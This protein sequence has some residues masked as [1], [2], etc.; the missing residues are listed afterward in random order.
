MRILPTS[1]AA[2]ALWVVLAISSPASSNA[3][4]DPHKVAAELYGDQPHVANADAAEH[5]IRRRAFEGINTL[6]P[7]ANSSDYYSELSRPGYGLFI[8]TNLARLTRI[9]LRNGKKLPLPNITLEDSTDPYAPAGGQA[10][11]MHWD[12][13]ATKSYFIPLAIFLAA[14][15]ITFLSTCCSCCCICCCR[16]KRLGRS[17]KDPY[18][19][20][21]KFIAAF[22]LAL[23]TLAWMAAIAGGISGAHFFG[24]SV[25]ILSET[26]DNSFVDVQLTIGNISGAVNTTLDTI[27]VDTIT[28][29]KSA[30][31]KWISKDKLPPIQTKVDTMVG[32]CQT[33]GQKVDELVTLSGILTN[34]K[35][36][37]AA[38]STGSVAK[39]QSGLTTNNAAAH[40]LTTYQPITLANGNSYIYKWRGPLPPLLPDPASVETPRQH[41]DGLSDL[42]ATLQNEVSSGL[43]LTAIAAA[44][45]AAA[46]DLNGTVTARESDGIDTVTRDLTTQVNGERGN[47]TTTILDLNTTIGDTHSDMQSYTSYSTK[48]ELYR[49]LFSAVLFSLPGVILLFVLS[50]V[51]AKKPGMVRCCL[52]GSI[53]YTL[54][55][56]IATLFLFIFTVILGETCTL[57]FDRS[58]NGTAPIVSI[59]AT[60]DAD[61]GNYYAKA[62]VARD[63]C[64]AQKPFLDIIAAAV[65]QFDI[66]DLTTTFEQV[67]DEQDFSAATK[68]ISYKEMIGSIKDPRLAQAFATGL[69]TQV[70]SYDNPSNYILALKTSMTNLKTNLDNVVSSLPSTLNDPDLDSDAT[71][72]NDRALIL[73][74][75]QADMQSV[76]SKY[77]AIQGDV[78]LAIDLISTMQSLKST[79]MPTKSAEIQTASNAVPNAFNSMNTTLT[80][81]FDD[82]RTNVTNGI[83][84]LKAA[85]K[86][87]LPDALDVNMNPIR[88]DKI[89]KD[90]VDL[91]MG[92]CDG[93]LTGFDA[94]WFTFF[95]FGSAG[96][97]TIPVFISAANRLADREAG[98]PKGA[99]SKKVFKTGKS[100]EAEDRAKVKTKGKGKVVDDMEIG[101]IKWTVA[102]PASDGAG[103]IEKTALISPT[104]ATGGVMPNPQA[105]YPDADAHQYGGQ[106]AGFQY[107]N[108]HPPVELNQPPQYDGRPQHTRA[109]SISKHSQPQGSY[110]PY[111]GESVH[112]PQPQ[113]QRHSHIPQSPN[114]FMD[115]G[116]EMRPSWLGPAGGGAAQGGPSDGNWSNAQYMP[117][118]RHPNAPL[119]PTD[120]YAEDAGGYQAAAHY[121]P[122]NNGPDYS[123]RLSAAPHPQ[124]Y[125]QVVDEFSRR[126]SSQVPPNRNRQSSQQPGQYQPQFNEYNP[127]HQD[128]WD[129]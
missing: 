23:V 110:Q 122:S 33:M 2:I 14:I 10:I 17:Q 103:N 74:Y 89:A 50:G 26:V 79:S 3:M 56:L 72:V 57:M 100:K 69:S 54:L 7:Y 112:M 47:L 48:Y 119:T 67:V 83:P 88:C 128:Q 78:N 124:E 70:S 109:S 63:S 118:P 15:L 38:P 45:Q 19:G 11:V 92:V 114:V 55:A 91:E 8:W 43:D 53:P 129:Q 98:K 12:Q 76:R 82:V 95:I 65:P 85:I 94:F 125:E 34:A 24:R 60:V 13:A 93:V 41:V 101:Q 127:H 4:L 87:L 1:I 61:A 99:P 126:V 59:L 31:D 6:E 68:A 120:S 39:I 29:L 106:D 71:D 16:R 96:A 115:D 51:G 104:S 77:V 35:V 27:Q 5:R 64:F 32:A 58:D 107:Q 113:S 108:P 44:T 75:L 81:F 46:G 66:A 49:M 90:T 40:M 111:Q 62:M 36:A 42:H 105:M 116:P 73:P 102:T 86:A 18:S 30:L 22:G 84:P 20:G 25:Y 52:C 37:V 28:Q 97:L 21:Q 121:A 117:K 80:Q 9:N 123:R